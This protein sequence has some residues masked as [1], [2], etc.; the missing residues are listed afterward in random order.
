MSDTS[1]STSA[2]YDGRNRKAQE[3]KVI[4][5]AGTFVTQWG[6]NSADLQTSMT[7][8]ADASGNLG[9]TV[10]TSYTQTLLTTLATAG[11]ALGSLSLVSKAYYDAAGRL[12]D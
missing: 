3:S 10:S 5:G 11:G 8:P 6:Y 7:Y 4:N 12:V 1:G 2:W 9:E